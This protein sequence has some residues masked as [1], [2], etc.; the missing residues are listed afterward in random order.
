LKKTHLD[1]VV[2]IIHKATLAD[3]WQKYVVNVLD[4]NQAHT[5]PK[6]ISA[7]Y[8]LSETEC[9]FHNLDF[10]PFILKQLRLPEITKKAQDY[11]EGKQIETPVPVT[12]FDINDKLPI[13][14]EK[15]NP[16]NP[17]VAIER[18][19]EF[20]AFGFNIPI[21]S[22]F[23]HIGI[24]VCS[25]DKT[26]KNTYCLWPACQPNVNN[27]E[28]PMDWIWDEKNNKE[29]AIING[30]V[31]RGD[32]GW[33]AQ[34]V[35]FL[36]YEVIHG[37]KPPDA[38]IEKEPT[39]SDDEESEE[40]DTQ[41]KLTQ[42]RPQ[43]AAKQMQEKTKDPKEPASEENAQKKLAQKRPPAAAKKK[44]ETKKDPKEPKK[45]KEKPID[46]DHPTYKETKLVSV[47]SQNTSKTA[48]END[49]ESKDDAPFDGNLHARLCTFEVA[50]EAYEAIAVSC[51]HIY[52][53]GCLFGD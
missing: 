35:N 11:N 15:W 10:E 13:S 9:N 3:S 45:R 49:T 14:W 4:P 41:K 29:T 46:R 12:K 22:L 38:V 30:I 23:T 28:I 8:T 53:I 20:Q 31:E 47:I 50:V 34:K 42:K 26:K 40:E 33:S 17:D 32:L 21:L 2:D 51:T 44:Q 18:V 39:S 6:I 37:S 43:A 27:R 5:I 1:K 48:A 52:F 24:R 25:D 16:E 7:F 19:F 36:P